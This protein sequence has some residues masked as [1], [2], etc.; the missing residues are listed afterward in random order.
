MTKKADLVRQVSLVT[1]DWAWETRKIG[2]FWL[3]N[4]L[5]I[6]LNVVTLLAMCLL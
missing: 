4:T 3:E 5:A 2:T 1:V 6:S